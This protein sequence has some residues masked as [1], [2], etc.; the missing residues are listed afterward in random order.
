M[1]D[2]LASQFYL[3]FNNFYLRA[4]PVECLSRIEQFISEWD[5]KIARYGLVRHY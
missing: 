2:V 5:I 4:G 1:G 3:Y